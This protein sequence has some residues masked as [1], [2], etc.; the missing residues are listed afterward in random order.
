MN[1]LNVDQNLVWNSTIPLNIQETYKRY[2]AVINAQ[3]AKANWKSSS[4]Y[5]SNEQIAICFISKAFWYKWI[6]AFQH[7][8]LYPDIQA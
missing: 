2:V 6:R 8:H 3:K 5:P 1:N 4:N 7:V